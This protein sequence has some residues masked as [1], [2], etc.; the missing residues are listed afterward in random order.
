MIHR[1]VEVEGAIAALC[2]SLYHAVIASFGEC[3]SVELHT[4]VASYHSKFFGRRGKNMHQSCQRVAPRWV[5]QTMHQSDN[6]MVASGGEMMVELHAHVRL[7]HTIDNP[8]H[9][10]IDTRGTGG[11]MHSVGEADGDF[12]VV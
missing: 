11:Q 6:R 7:W 1:Q 3:L 8:Q 5:A 10:G 12:L 2:H 4:L 9:R